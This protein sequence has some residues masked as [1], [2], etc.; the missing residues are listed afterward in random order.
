VSSRTARRAALSGFRGEL[1]RA[2][3][4]GRA[5]AGDRVRIGSVGVDL[6]LEVVQMCE[7]HLRAGEGDVAVQ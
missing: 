7:N 6:T 5:V 1:W 2:R 4:S 3:C